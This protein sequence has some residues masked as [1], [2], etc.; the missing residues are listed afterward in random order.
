MG[1]Q[2]KI[3]LIHRIGANVV[4]TESRGEGR[5]RS[6]FHGRWEGL[7]Q[8]PREGIVIQQHLAIGWR[9]I[10]PDI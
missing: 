10:Y 4:S 9:E 6:F 2:W 5:V 1:K 7:W 3:L 8:F